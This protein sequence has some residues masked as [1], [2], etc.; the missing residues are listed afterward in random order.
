[1][2]YTQLFDRLPSLRLA[3]EAGTL[4]YTNAM[5]Y[6]VAHVPVTWDTAAPTGPEAAAR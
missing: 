3:A 4:Q 1:V 5:V 6:G 2:I